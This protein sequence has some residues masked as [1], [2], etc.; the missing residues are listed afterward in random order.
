MNRSWQ[1]WLG[2]AIFVQQ[3]L[4]L[5]IWACQSHCYLQ[6]P[7]EAGSSHSCSSELLQ[8]GQGHCSLLQSVSADLA[9]P[10]D[11]QSLAGLPHGSKCV[12]EPKPYRS[13]SL[14]PHK[15]RVS[16]GV[17]VVCLCWYDSQLLFWIRGSWFSLPPTSLTGHLKG[18]DLWERETLIMGFHSSFALP[19]LWC[20][21]KPQLHGLYLCV[22]S[23]GPSFVSPGHET[24]EWQCRGVH[25]APELSCSSLHRGLLAE[26]QLP[27]HV[28][29]WGIIAKAPLPYQ[30][31]GWRSA[32]SDP[33]PSDGDMLTPIPLLQSRPG[34]ECE[35][36]ISSRHTGG[37]TN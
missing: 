30:T 25:A 31:P 29:T 28:T 8:P 1:T 3:Q 13:P 10:L 37:Q 5:Q 20:K 7:C 35:P 26:T 16:G 33:P 18:E 6:S 12:W 21:W 15:S 27:V 22:L 2:C 11:A 24:T 23:W 32:D 34:T 9:I 14:S 19:L 4:V 17:G 36:A